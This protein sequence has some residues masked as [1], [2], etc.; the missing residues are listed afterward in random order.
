MLGN[1]LDGC[2]S[3]LFFTLFI[4]LK[5]SDNDFEGRNVSI[6]VLNDSGGIVDLVH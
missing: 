2:P 4:C 6:N 1:R 5:C 3:T